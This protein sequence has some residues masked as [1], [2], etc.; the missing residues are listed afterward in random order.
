MERLIAI[1][2]GGNRGV[3]YET[4]GEL[5]RLG[6]LVVLTC[7]NEVE[8]QHAVSKLGSDDIVFHKL[9]V[10]DTKEI[11]ALRDWIVKTYWQP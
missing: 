3:G 7:R 10:I 1:V 4:C 11:E 8:G 5:A 6:C 9:D 2:T